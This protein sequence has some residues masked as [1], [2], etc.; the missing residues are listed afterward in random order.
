MQA[1]LLISFLFI[2]S[3]TYQST[4]QKNYKLSNDD[5]TV[6]FS[7]F[8]EQSYVTKIPDDKFF[9]LK[10]VDDAIYEILQYVN[11][12][13]DPP[14]GQNIYDLMRRAIAGNITL[15]EVWQSE[16]YK[17][18]L[19]NSQLGFAICVV[20]GLSL[21]VVVPLIGLI[22]FVCRCCCNKCRP[23][24]ELP[25]N[26]QE[27]TPS[28]CDNC[29]RRFFTFWLI[30]FVLI[31]VVCGLML[32]WVNFDLGS[33]TDNLQ[34]T[35][36][37][38]KTDLRTYSKNVEK[39]YQY[40]ISKQLL[41]L[42]E[43]LY[44]LNLN[45]TENTLG[46][47]IQN[48]IIEDNPKFAEAN[49]TLNILNEQVD[50]L[51]HL[52]LD[53]NKNSASAVDDQT[54]LLAD[55]KLLMEDLNTTKSECGS[56][57]DDIPVTQETLYPPDDDFEANFAKYDELLNL[58][59][60]MQ[61]LVIKSKK[62]FDIIPADTN[63]QTLDVQKA[64]LQMLDEAS[65]S[66]HSDCY[67]EI[68]KQVSNISELLPGK[69][70]DYEDIISNDIYRGYVGYGVAA[71]LL[72][73]AI[74]LTLAVCCGVCGYD[75]EATPAQ[76]TNI[77]H[78]GGITLILVTVL[79]FLTFSLLMLLGL[80]GLISGG[81]FRLMMCEDES[82]RFLEKVVDVRDTVPGYP[83]NFATSVLYGQPDND[84]VK[85]AQL[86]REC[87]KGDGS[88]T[89]GLKFD[90]YLKP[91]LLKCLSYDS[92]LGRKLNNELQEI[93]LDIKTDDLLPTLQEVDDITGVYSDLLQDVDKEAQAFL[94]KLNKGEIEDYSLS[95]LS[96][97]LSNFA[98]ELISDSADKIVDKDERLKLTKA[99]LELQ[100][101]AK[102][103]EKINLQYLE[104]L[105]QTRELMINQLGQLTDKISKIQNGDKIASAD[106]G[107]G[108]EAYD[109]SSGTVKALVKEATENLAQASR[110]K[111]PYASWDKAASAYQKR[112]S[113]FVDA[114]GSYLREEVDS[115]IGHC[116][117]LSQIHS[118]LFKTS[119]DQV[120]AD[121]NQFWFFLLIATLS[122][123]PLMC[124]GLKL[125]TH[126][127]ILEPYDPQET[128]D[129]RFQAE[130]V[131][132]KASSPTRASTNP[133][134]PTSNYSNNNNNDRH[135]S[136]N[137]RHSQNYQQQPPPQSLSRP[138]SKPPSHPTQSPSTTP[139]SNNYSPMGPQSTYEP[140]QYQPINGDSED[141]PGMKQTSI[142]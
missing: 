95:T 42:K 117:P 49:G 50:L 132:L 27:A 77:S 63:G 69:A 114:Y 135:L 11:F 122:L 37:N 58:E 35:L 21:A 80:S 61:I 105:K 25:K 75:G 82:Y 118:A 56:E 44:S 9:L 53:V 97:K 96:F 101:A 13:K 34:T 103:M 129:Q 36:E 20:V 131:P 31:L 26:D 127:R 32:L 138:T 140:V 54:S 71:L 23:K 3:L 104:K 15:S 78:C 43:V 125:S 108:F 67:K 123:L 7:A 88:A 81:N 62:Q 102:E 89:V 90:Q 141:Q 57:C 5:E 112:L 52:Y 10:Y 68:V 119:C 12:K 22:I 39:G 14:Y 1:N 70:S 106:A 38:G 99:Q 2:G 87:K 66:R 93:E 115:N 48:Q 124:I 18:T 92:E 85:L 100:Q 16:E 24:Y 111:F 8:R 137:L 136:L 4:A 121:Y 91:P 110:A 116:K 29:T 120:L 94:D 65:A 109:I 45:D 113:G 59:I 72:L 86:I 139:S 98:D 130:G 126:Y 47:M 142:C 6:T 133:R 30:V 84:E 73:L 28:S 79:L 41:S 134:R 128:F 60:D 19:L 74:C 76:R 46:V 107:S 33:S 55:L 40:A 51:L 64:I 83:G 17:D